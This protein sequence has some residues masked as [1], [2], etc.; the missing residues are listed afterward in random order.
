MEVGVNRPHSAQTNKK[1]YKTSARV[2][3]PGEKEGRTSKTDLVEKCRGGDQACWL[4]MGSAAPNQVRWRRAVPAMCSQGSK[5]E[6][7]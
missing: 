6:N 4:D 3:S 1:H 2:E 7:K 5:E